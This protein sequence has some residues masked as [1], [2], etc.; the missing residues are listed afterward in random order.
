[1]PEALNHKS[2]NGYTPLSIA[3]LAYQDP[4]LAKLLIEAGADERARDTH[5]RNMLHY[6]LVPVTVYPGKAGL[7][8]TSNPE[9]FR[10]MLEPFDK[11]E[12][13]AMLLE[14]CHV[15][16]KISAPPLA[17]WLYHTCGD[18]HDIE[19]LGTLRSFADDSVLEMIDE[20]GNLPLHIAVK[21]GFPPI[22]GQLISMKPALLHRENAV[23][24]T[25][26]ELARDLWIQEVVAEPP[27]LEMP[28]ASLIRDE[29]GYLSVLD[30]PAKEFVPDKDTEAES[31]PKPNR[32]RTYEV[33]FESAAQYPHKRR[34]VSLFEANE[35]AKSLVTKNEEE[36]SC[37]P[38]RDEVDDWLPS[39]AGRYGLEH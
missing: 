27:N 20:A 21:Q 11:H 28:D 18:I 30:R 22:V 26:L 9:A 8:P 39:G 24:I 37:Q 16:G 10:A 2:K 35:L 7:I 25:P 3:V 33:C 17:Y 38:E 29:H 36:S 23:G 12:L 34:L 13:A 19:I 6:L 14:R 31:E 15:P 5:G 32:R 4:P 1:M